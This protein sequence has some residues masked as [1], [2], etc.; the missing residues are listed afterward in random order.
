MNS[1]RALRHFHAA[2]TVAWAVMIPVSLLTGLKHSVPFLVGISVYALAGAHWAS[3]QA[4]RSEE[5]AE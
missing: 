1:P 2:M 4:T 5:A 3:W